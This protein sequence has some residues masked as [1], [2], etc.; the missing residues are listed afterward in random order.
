MQSVF[1]MKYVDALMEKQRYKLIKEP[2]FVFIASDPNVRTVLLFFHSMQSSNN[3]HFRVAGAPTCLYSLVVWNIIKYVFQGLKRM[4]SK[5]TMGLTHFFAL[6]YR[7][8]GATKSWQTLGSYSCRRQI[9]V[10]VSNP[11]S[12]PILFLKPNNLFLQR[13]VTCSTCS[14]NTERFGPSQSA[15]ESA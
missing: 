12:N 10:T 7:S 3:K 1:K 2:R 14:E 4:Q 9:W 6:T 5:V 13:L 8:Y 11:N 15:P